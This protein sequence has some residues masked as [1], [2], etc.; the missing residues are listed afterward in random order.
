MISRRRFV[1]ATAL[2]AAASTLPSASRETMAQTAPASVA[3][4]GS[5]GTSALTLVA[6]KMNKLQT[7]ANYDPFISG[8]LATITRFMFEGMQQSG[9]MDRLSEHIQAHGLPDYDPSL[10]QPHFESL[11]KAGVRMS[12]SD[13]QKL[14]EGKVTSGADASTMVVK[15]NSQLGMEAF[16]VG[17]YNLI[18]RRSA[19]PAL[20]I[21]VPKQTSAVKNATGHEPVPAVFT[22]D[23][24]LSAHPRLLAAA[25]AAAAGTGTLAPGSRAEAMTVSPLLGIPPSGGKMQPMCGPQ[26]D[27]QGKGGSNGDSTDSHS[28][29]DPCEPGTPGCGDDPDTSED[30]YGNLVF[31]NAI[32]VSVAS[33]CQGFDRVIALGAGLTAAAIKAWA[34]IDSA[35]A[36]A[37]VN[38]LGF[39]T[40]DLF[41]SLL[42]G[43][44]GVAVYYSQFC[45]DP[46]G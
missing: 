9:L 24:A 20:Q 36:K 6:Q 33:V 42:A 3:G 38:G 34:S 45:S 25:A 35:A 14:F 46:I 15:F 1:S 18:K 29:V 11:A 37:F 26:G 43:I 22:V 39:A 32:Y 5:F 40:V 31:E 23:D 28:G 8:E 41:A 13:M 4:N 16:H 27:A 44:G 21:A 12:P 30:Q 10:L 19:D 2:A 17:L 7:T